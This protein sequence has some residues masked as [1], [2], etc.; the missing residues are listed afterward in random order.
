MASTVF[1]RADEHMQINPLCLVLM[2]EHTEQDQVGLLVR[3]P[4]IVRKNR[5]TFVS[6]I[7]HLPIHFI[8][9]KK[10]IKKELHFIPERKLASAEATQ[11]IQFII[12]NPHVLNSV[13]EKIYS[14]VQKKEIDRVVQT[15]FHSFKETLAKNKISSFTINTASNGLYL[16]EQNNEIIHHVG[17]F[18][19]THRGGYFHFSTFVATLYDHV[20]QTMPIDCKMY[21][22]LEQ[23][24]LGYYFEFFLHQQNLWHQKIYETL[25]DLL[26]EHDQFLMR[27]LTVLEQSSYEQPNVAQLIEKFRESM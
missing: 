18:K 20:A 11:L 12:Q 3:V 14:L 9:K 4:T 5:T 7:A 24:K 27:V 26:M 17:E 16:I 25:P 22:F 15:M 23:G 13:E 8:P 21:L 1:L 2:D 19:A 6:S 10:T